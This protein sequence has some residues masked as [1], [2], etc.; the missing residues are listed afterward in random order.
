[1]EVVILLLILAGMLVWFLLVR[2]EAPAKTEAPYKVEAKQEE[3]KIVVAPVVVTPTVP[4]MAKAPAKPKAKAPVKPKA[5][6]SVQPA[7]PVKAKV[8]TEKKNANA[9]P[10]KAK[11]QNS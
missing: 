11:Q 4:K 3:K 1:M 8:T 2:R 7:Q 6:A 5:K 10:K 9:K